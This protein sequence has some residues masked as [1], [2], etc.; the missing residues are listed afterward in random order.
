MNT[1][2]EQYELAKV[3]KEIELKT[4][5]GGILIITIYEEI[6]TFLEQ[7]VELLEKDKHKA[8]DKVNTLLTKSQALITE[9]ILSLNKTPNE[10]LYNNLNNLY[11]YFNQELREANF[12]KDSKK[13]TPIINFLKE[14]LESWKEVVQKNKKHVPNQRKG[15]NISL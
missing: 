12:N 2:K 7:A 8:F 13:I 14:L 4:A 6:I 3:Y 5:D 9:L 10:S 11:L 15:L 1:N